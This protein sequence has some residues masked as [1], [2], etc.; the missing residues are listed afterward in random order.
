MLK[1]ASV[2]KWPLLAL[3]NVFT[4]VCFQLKFTTV[5]LWIYPVGAIRNLSN[6]DIVLTLQIFVFPPVIYVFFLKTHLPF[7]WVFLC[8]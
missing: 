5:N 3:Y 2:R 4:N 1:S 7:W 6:D 8:L